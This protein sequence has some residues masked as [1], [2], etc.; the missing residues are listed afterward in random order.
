MWLYNCITEK[1]IDEADKHRFLIMIK[2]DENNR[3]DFIMLKFQTE[4][5]QQDIEEIVGRICQAKNEAEEHVLKIT[6]TLI[7]EE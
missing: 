3:K 5:E 2:D 1:Y 6:L 4:P 7:E